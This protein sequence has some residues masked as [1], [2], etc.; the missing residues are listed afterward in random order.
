MELKEAIRS[1]LEGKAILFAGSGFSWGATNHKG[2]AFL[3]GLGLRD[4]LAKE[5]GID[6]TDNSLSSVSDYYLTTSGH[7]YESLINLLVDTFKLGKIT[8]THKK[9]MSI[10]WKRI[11]T[12]N[13]DLVIETGAEFNGRI[14]RTVVLTDP[15][16]TQNKEN[17]CVHINGSIDNLSK[18]TLQ[19]SFKL[20]DRSYDA[21]SLSGTPWFDFMERDFASAKA[22]IIVGFSMQSDIDIRRILAR[23][24]IAK[25]VVFITAPNPDPISKNIL[26]KYAPVEAIG[27]DGFAE[28][29]ETEKRLFVP[30]VI[31]TH[32]YSSFLHEHMVPQEKV[33]TRLAD[34]TAFYYL[35]SVGPSILQKGPD[36][37]YSNLTLR[38]AVNVFLRYRT[39]YRVFL[40]VSN[41][42]NGKTLFCDLVRNELRAVD[43]DVFTLSKET[44]DTVDE[45]EYI[46]HTYRGKHTVIIIDDYY[47]HLDAL[48][49]FGSFGDLSKMTFVLTSRF[50][51][52]S[53][54]YR[55]LIQVLHIQEHEVKPL[56]LNELSRPETKMLAEVLYR[57]KMLGGDLE[58]SS[59]RD[60][61]EFIRTDC[62]SS[63]GDVVLKLFDS[64]YIKNELVALYTKA[65]ENDT[66]DLREVAVAALASE[67]MNLKLSLDDIVDLLHIDFVLL[68]LKDNEL[69]DELFDSTSNELKVKSPVVARKILRDIIPLETLLSVLSKLLSS[70][71]KYCLSNSFYAEV[72]KAIVSHANFTYWIKKAESIKLIKDFYDN[73]RTIPFFS[74]KNPF[75]WEQFASICIDSQDF[76]T[77]KQCLNNAFDEAS[78]I[79]GFVPFQVETVYARYLINELRYRLNLYLIPEREIMNC[80]LEANNRLFKYYS[81]PEDEHY[82]VFQ[83]FDNIVEVFCVHL[84]GFDRR[85]T[86]IFL[87]KMVDAQRLLTQYQAETESKYFPS[88][89]KWLTNLNKA[90]DVA[91]THIK[92]LTKKTR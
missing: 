72:M 30:S 22:I 58:R 77:A 12:T 9:I 36:G 81:H 64:S 56:R 60:V 89:Q 52:L 41:I 49:T 35:G 37:N 65:T 55:K 85:D 62:R 6:K 57:N 32:D 25:K 84:S 79:R 40:A 86:S 74:S 10:R 69:I 75:F 70:A 11:Y 66:D 51:K 29:I 73:L 13:Y 43:V 14:L 53:S 44:I 45:I 78:K 33:P 18:K 21:E 61:E 80:L 91:K 88:T 31:A 20:T 48:K 4:K 92:D 3:T 7:S 24:Q 5:C 26:K 50:S 39:Q 47:K 71:D 28:S 38:D 8:E 2:E 23:P 17:V 63:I 15:F 76:L 68:K 1:A 34:L 83:L 87:E 46:F 16:E 42:G 90:I 27:V 59:I 82:H 19:S 67:V 54:N